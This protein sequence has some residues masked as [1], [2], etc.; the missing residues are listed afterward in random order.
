M[1]ALRDYQL[2][3]YQQ[4]VDS[5]RHGHTSIIVQSPPRTGKTV[6]MA[7]IAR[8]TTQAGKRIL[9]IVHRKE[10]VDQV[11]KTFK[12]QEVDMSLA[13]IGMVQTFTRHV[14]KLKSPAVL[15]VDEAHHVL[16]KS[17]RRILDAF[18]QAIKLLFTA[19]PIRLNGN[20]FESVAD[21]LINGKSIQWLIHHGNLAPVKYF[22]PKQ[23]DTSVLK[24]K[25]TGEFTEE[26]I[27]RA[28]KP[29]I[30]GNAVKHY[31]KLAKGL[32]AIA[33]TYNVSSAHQ[34]ADEFNRQGITAAAVD[35]STPKEERKKIISDYRNGKIQIVTNNELFTEGLDL[36]NVDCVIMLRP[37]QSL[38]LYLQFS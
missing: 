9:F 20:G 38:A 21:D 4:I 33:Y 22:A 27:E 34:L 37:T 13:Q 17:Y 31:L 30:Y 5:M 15:F 28:S 12:D 36:P 25:R 14:E 1:F 16:A 6:L 24:A 23:I 11:I 29:K 7:E 2:E 3:E 19:T 18:P 32:Q 35:G 8:K 10:I 26:S